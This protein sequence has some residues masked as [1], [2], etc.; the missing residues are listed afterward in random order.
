MRKEL[1]FTVATLGV[2]LGACGD[3]EQDYPVAE[4]DGYK[5]EKPADEIIIIS[6]R[7]WNVVEGLEEVAERCEI[8]SI[9]ASSPEIT[10][11]KIYIV[12]SNPDCFSELE[13]PE[14][15]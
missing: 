4:G 9:A 13:T 7:P 15:R 1:L 14:S 8:S 10:S 2:A 5:I 12:V 6:G 3:N 11:E